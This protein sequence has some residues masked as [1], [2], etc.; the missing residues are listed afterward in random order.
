M[1]DAQIQTEK[2][3]GRSARLTS[4]GFAAAAVSA[5]VLCM[6][7]VDPLA[8]Q[9]AREMRSDLRELFQTITDLGKSG[10]ILTLAGVCAAAFAVLRRRAGS[11]RNR[12]AWGYAMQV[13]LFVLAAVAVTGIAVSLIKN[14]IGRARPKHFEALG[15][16]DFTPFAFQA[17]FAAFPS[18]HATTIF[19]L[20]TA[21]AILWPRL[22][23]IVLAA[24][25][26]V[27]ASRFLI[28]AHYLSDV[29]AGTAFGIAGTLML[30]AALSRRRW[31]FEP[32]LTAPVLRGRRIRSYIAQ[33][34][35]LGVLRQGR[36]T[37]GNMATVA[38]NPAQGRAGR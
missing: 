9:A 13:S 5:I 21:V 32:G 38:G 11:R 31:L 30:R 22:R 35:R 25:L 14:S 23:Y 16:F 17:D 37:R 36:E 3:A 4:L 34:A 12:A 15:S 33:R 20:A 28:G 2:T 24:A 19:A 1:Y 29:L 6:L 26:I 18:G 8:F 10:W 7:L 27:A